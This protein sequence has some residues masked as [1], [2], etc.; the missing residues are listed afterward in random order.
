ML[1]EDFIMSNLLYI[2]ASPR[3]E[4]STSIAIAK[5]FLGAYQQN[6]PQDKIKTLELFKMPIP[7]FDGNIINAKYAILH[8]TNP[9]PQERAAWKSVEDLINEF[10]SAD[11]YVFAV[12]M[13][14]FGIPYRLK[15]YID[16]LLQPTYTFTFSPQDGYKGLITGKSAFIVYARG[17][18]YG[19]DESLD[20]QKRYLECALRFIGFTDLRSIIIEG[21]LMKSKDESTKDRES[22]IAKA[23]EMAKV[24]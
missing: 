12:P 7:E 19:S 18:V 11:K 13:W 20:F 8:G 24:F 6:H 16:N 17:G 15:N 4:R 1:W 23:R 5:A 2:E 22:A 21:T 9:T 14:N 3:A 10:K